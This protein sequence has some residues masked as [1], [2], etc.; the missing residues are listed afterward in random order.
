MEPLSLFPVI[1]ILGAIWSAWCLAFGF[2]VGCAWFGRKAE[3]EI[4]AAFEYGV[5]VGKQEFAPK[6]DDHGRFAPKHVHFPDEV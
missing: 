4:D 2:V 5:T 1:L 6:R 3:K